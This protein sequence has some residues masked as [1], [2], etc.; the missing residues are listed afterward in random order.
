MS[1]EELP[2]CDRELW[3]RG[4]HI[5]TIWDLR[6]AQ[7]EEAVKKAAARSG[8]RM[9]WHYVGGRACVRALG[10]DLFAARSHLY[11]ELGSHQSYRFTT[12]KD[13][14]LPISLLK[15]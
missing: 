4:E 12:E 5:A 7:I 3:E 2:S 14:V 9:D 6:P 1:G 15:S 11:L 13:S 8:Q 10:D